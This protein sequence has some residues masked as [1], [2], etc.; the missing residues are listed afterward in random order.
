MADRR[1]SR[2]CRSTAG[3][4]T[5]AHA[6]WLW[7]CLAGFGLGLFGLEYCRRR[8][9]AGDGPRGESERRRASRS[10]DARRAGPPRGRATADGRLD[11]VSAG[12]RAL[13]LVEVSVSNTGSGIGTGSCFLASRTSECAP[14]PWSK[15]HDPAVVVGVAVG[16]DAEHLRQRAGDP[17]QEAAGRA[18][19]RARTGPAGPP[20]RR[21]RRTTAARRAR[22]P[23]ATS[24]RT[25][26]RPRSWATVADLRLVVGVERVVA[27][28][29][30]RDQPRV[31]VVDRQQVAR[32]QVAG[33]DPL[34]VGH[35]RRAPRSPRRRGSARSR[36][37]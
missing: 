2:C 1:S 18:A 30:R 19:V 15:R 23:R 9:K 7:T 14:Q 22:G 24:V 20:G 10:R 12:V 32:R 4:R 33:L 17:H 29:V 31:V 35:P 6:W 36:R 25:R 3:S 5:R 21:R 13:D 8:R 28:G 26:P 27:E 11:L 16:A 37:R 34:A